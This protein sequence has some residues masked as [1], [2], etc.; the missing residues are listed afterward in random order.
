MGRVT[1]EATQAAFESSS[2][3]LIC[4]V[5]DGAN[6][7]LVFQRSDGEAADADGVH[8]EYSDQINGGY[9]CVRH[10]ALSRT[11][12]SVDLSRQLGDLRG[13]EGFDVHLRIAD[14]DYAKFR[15][16]LQSVFRD[17]PDVLAVA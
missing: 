7:Y 6:R 12:L 11:G 3:V 1:F 9:R 2:E 14:A 5:S 16:G 8:L 17:T 13:V 4:G 10:C 15:I